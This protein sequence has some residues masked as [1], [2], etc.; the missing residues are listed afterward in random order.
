MNYYT[1]VGSRKTPA[2][3]CTIMTQIA[4]KLAKRGYI[5]RSGAADGADAA[6]EAG[7]NQR[8]TEHPPEIYL[9][10]LG[11]NGSKSQ[12]L[13]SREAFLMAEQFHP[14]WGRCSPAARCMHAR[15]CHQVLGKDLKTPSEFLICWT[16]DAAAGGGTG[17]A[18]RIAK[19]YRIPVYD[20]GDPEVDT[21]NL[22]G[23]P[24]EHHP[25]LDC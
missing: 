7:A 15:N 11:F 16:Q 14:A 22:T 13:P 12:L 18:I 20:L 9:P 23:E 17:Q 4:A 1:G 25:A 21:I 10:W 2:E 8:L 5:L 3:V 24:Y 19:H 6:F